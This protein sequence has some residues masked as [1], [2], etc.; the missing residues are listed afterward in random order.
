MLTLSRAPGDHIDE[1]PICHSEP[2]LLIC[3][4]LLPNTWTFQNFWFYFMIWIV[5]F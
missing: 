1:L 4:V 3:P 2:V 5:V